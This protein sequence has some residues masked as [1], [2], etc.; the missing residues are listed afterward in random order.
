MRVERWSNDGDGGNL[1]N[2]FP[3]LTL[4]TAD[5]SCSGEAHVFQK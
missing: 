2:T 3:S 1:R 5:L 4:F